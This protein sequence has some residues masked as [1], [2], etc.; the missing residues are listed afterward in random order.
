MLY[1]PVA[2]NKFSAIKHHKTRIGREIWRKNMNPSIFG[3]KD[4]C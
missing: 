3:V 2:E 4:E 1:T